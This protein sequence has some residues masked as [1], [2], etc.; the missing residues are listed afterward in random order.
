MRF[1]VSKM[2]VNRYVGNV[3]TKA[4][5]FWQC[6]SG[7]CLIRSELTFGFWYKYH[8]GATYVT[9]L[10]SFR[11]EVRKTQKHTLTDNGTGHMLQTRIE[12]SNFVVAFKRMSTGN[13]NRNEITSK[14]MLD[15]NVKSIVLSLMWFWKIRF[16]NYL[17]ILWWIKN[18]G[19]KIIATARKNFWFI[20]NG[21]MFPPRD[22]RSPWVRKTYGLIFLFWTLFNVFKCL[23]TWHVLIKSFKFLLLLLITVF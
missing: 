20:A 19:S 21:L 16:Q 22:G 4:W 8:A 2:H 13:V 3:E 12:T 14:R 7:D 23:K 6:I 11:V 18:D 1:W 5:N 9:E 15:G 10:T 17:K